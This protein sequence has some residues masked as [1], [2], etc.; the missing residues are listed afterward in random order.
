MGSVGASSHPR[1]GGCGCLSAHKQPA[2]LHR[3][4]AVLF[5]LTPLG[6][7]GHTH[8]ALA[9]GWALFGGFAATFWSVSG[10]TVS[11]IGS[12]WYSYIKLMEGAKRAPA[13]LP[14]H[15]PSKAASPTSSPTSNSSK[16]E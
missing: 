14:I 3:G 15:T 10:I 9:P 16:P 6:S 8:P 11:F 1:P 12:G 13:T 4:L 2:S 5:A 7:L